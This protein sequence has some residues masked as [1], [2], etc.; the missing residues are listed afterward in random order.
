M[1]KN[2]SFGKYSKRAREKYEFQHEKT[3]M[4]KLVPE[5]LIIHGHQKQ[6]YGGH[7]ELRNFCENYTFEAHGLRMGIHSLCFISNTVKKRLVPHFQ[8]S[9]VVT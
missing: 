1:S 7:S 6:A 8:N 4:T 5:I 3:L 2:R 9:I